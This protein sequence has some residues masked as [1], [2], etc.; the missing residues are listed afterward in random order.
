[1][2][3]VEGLGNVK[4]DEEKRAGYLAL[5]ISNTSNINNI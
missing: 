5:Y 2:E 3:E 1:M 4:D